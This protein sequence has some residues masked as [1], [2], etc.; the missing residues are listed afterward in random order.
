[1]AISQLTSISSYLPEIFEDAMFVAREQNLMSN[2]VFNYSGS[3]F[4]IRNVPVRPAIT[5]EGIADAVDYNAPTTWTK[6]AGATLTP[7]EIIA[8]ALLTDQ[9]IESDQEDATRTVSIELGGAIATKI[10][11]DVLSDFSSLTA[12]AGPGAG[13]ALNYSYLAAAYVLASTAAKSAGPFYAVLHPYQWHD[14]WVELGRP[15]ATYDFLGD[16]ANEAM[17]SYA[18][19][20]WVGMT[21]FTSANITIDASDDAVGAVFHREALALDTRRAPRLEAERDASL[22]ATELNMTAGYAHGVRRSTYGRY[23]TSDATTPAGS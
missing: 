19:G 8:Q 6:S 16:V 11:V 2:L 15:A 3:G 18:V 12:E 23:I 13:N 9:H 10:D 14:I 17:R 22:R 7:G 1:V 21:W 4:M 20:N 5:A